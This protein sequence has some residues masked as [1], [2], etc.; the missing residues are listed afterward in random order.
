MASV[1]VITPREYSNEVKILKV[2]L[3]CNAGEATFSD[4]NIE[5][6]SKR[7]MKVVTVPGTPG[8]TDNSDISLTDSLSGVNLLATNGVDKVDNTATNEIA[9]D[10]TSN[11][12]IGGLTLAITGNAVNAAVV[13]VYLVFA[14]D[15]QA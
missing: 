4:V 12:V 8:P 11:I 7:L 2:V 14:N 6:R 5:E 1:N 3:T 10:S 9:P 15:Y 13:T